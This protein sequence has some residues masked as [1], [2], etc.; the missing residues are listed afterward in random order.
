MIARDQPARILIT[1]SAGFI[2]SSLV[3]HLIEQTC[4]TVIGLDSFEHRGDSL[5]VTQLGIDPDRYSIACADLAAPISRRLGAELGALDAIINLAALSNVDESLADP[6]RYLLNNLA[7]AVNVFDFARAVGSRCVVQVS[8]DEVYGP[9]APGVAFAEWSATRPSNPYSASKACQE[10]VAIAFWRSYGVPSVVVNLMNVIGERQEPTKFVPL[11]VKQVLRGEE[12]LVHA[13]GGRSGSRAYLYA[14]DA[15]DAILFLLSESSPSGYDG[16]DLCV[17][18][19][20]NIAGVEEVDNVTLALAVGDIL[21]REVRYRM[22]D[23]ATKRPGHDAR[24]ALDGTK[25]LELGWRPRVGF[26][27]ALTTTVRWLVQHPE[28]LG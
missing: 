22:V 12:V 9:A 6:S 11:L 14:R 27:H 1:G 4:W 7:V 8:T 19:R 17:P 20:Y 13:C 24:Y 3:R 16:T 21:G 18:D 28:W 5:R 10:A 23:G 25:L 15:A 2:G 26:S